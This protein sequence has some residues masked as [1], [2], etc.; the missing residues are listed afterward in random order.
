V[1]SAPGLPSQLYREEL[2]TALVS[3]V[4]FH[5]Q[6]NLLV[7]HDVKYRRLYRPSSM[8]MDSMDAE[9]SRGDV[10]L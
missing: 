2:V 9:V 8:S 7:M 10:S 3:L 5:L 4:K 6:Y 1:L